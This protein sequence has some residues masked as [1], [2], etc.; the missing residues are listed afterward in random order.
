MQPK[1]PLTFGA[2]Y[3]VVTEIASGGMG[4]VYL[5]LRLDADGA[6][7]PVAIKALH[8]HL[9]DDP[10]MVASFLDEAR[11]A[12]RIVH[13]NVVRVEDV[14]MIGDQLVIV[15]EYVEGVALSLILKT[16]RT[17]ESALPIPV[18]RRMLHD[19]LL[20]LDAAHELRDDSG[21]YLGVVHRD[22]SPHNL[23]VA[24]DGLT[25]VSDFG[26]ATASGRVASTR[27]GGGVKGKL[28]YLSPEQIYRKGLDRRSDVFAA[29][30][31]LWECLTGRRLFS[32]GSE[33]ET[34]AMVLREP[35]APPSA[36]RFDVPIELDEI[37]LR[38]LERDPERR[39]QS[40]REL[41]EA[42]AEGPMASREEVAAIV[43]QAAPAT[44][45]SR[46][47]V[48]EQALRNAGFT[49]PSFAPAEPVSLDTGASAAVVEQSAA[50]R[51]TSRV[52]L[53]AALL[54]GIVAGG[55]V[56]GLA[57]RST[58]TQAASVAPPSPSSPTPAVSAIASVAAA[59]IESAP[60][61]AAVESAP[62]AKVAASAQP[63]S[64]P[65]SSVRATKKPAAGGRPFMP[66]DL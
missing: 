29:G 41:A 39:F 2:R 51:P 63:R 64:R 28:Q 32:A 59:T 61:P 27:T 55:V 6:K 36:H 22:V 25:R 30:T 42:L 53:V 45:A 57:A 13:P 46:R 50:R 66:S 38:A 3:R 60:P 7:H 18:V 15:M 43:A 33:G 1:L 5:A 10:D 31:V 26:I 48:L 49:Q 19:A 47:T 62:P 52:P 20:G 9:A 65:A 35:I 40:A 23:L 54:V 12:S 16:T 8:A 21:G 4:A 34:L 37:C 24:A 56:V 44:I 17:R 58:S 11:I 14:E